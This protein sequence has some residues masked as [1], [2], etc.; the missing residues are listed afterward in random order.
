MK[1]VIDSVSSLGFEKHLMKKLPQ[2]LTAQTVNDL[3]DTTVHAIAGE[4][5]E[6]RV[7]RAQ[8]AEK[9]KVLEDTLGVLR[10]LERHRPVC[11]DCDPGVAPSTDTHRV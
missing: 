9:L 8:A 4:T 3:D 1:Q 5:E 6:S 7:E 11:L 2:I 10:R